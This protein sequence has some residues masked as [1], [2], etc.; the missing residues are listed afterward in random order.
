MVSRNRRRAEQLVHEGKAACAVEDFLAAERAFE[1]ALRLAPGE[2]NAYAGL[3]VVAWRQHR[4]IEASARYS[5]LVLAADPDNP[6][7]LL[8]RAVLEKWRGD[9]AAAT[10]FAQRVLRARPDNVRAL[11]ITYK[12]RPFGSDD[13]RFARIGQ[14]LGNP[15]LGN[16]EKSRL[17]FIKADIFEKENNFD[18]A[19]TQFT[20][21]NE[22]GA[23]LVNMQSKIFYEEFVHNLMLAIAPIAPV[24]PREEAARPIFVVGMPRSGSTLLEQILTTRTGV[25]SVGESSFLSQLWRASLRECYGETLDST[26]SPA[27]FRAYLTA[28]RLQAMRRAYLRQVAA[29]PAG[30][31]HPVIVDKELNNY[32]LLPLLHKLFPEAKIIHCR[33]HHLDV[34]FSCFSKNMMALS[35][36]FRQTTIAQMIRQYARVMASWRERGIDD[37]I[38]VTYEELVAQ[39]QQVIKQILGDCGVDFDES[40]LH[41][42]HSRNVV[43]TASGEQ[44]RREIDRSGVGRWRNYAAHLGPLVDAL[45]GWSWVEHQPHA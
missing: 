8:D 15:L 36:A 44:V 34:G 21:A 43:D 24:E 4:D 11:E 32:R 31:R 14:L 25:G 41:P 2:P 22:I 38:D 42:E 3:A 12:L 20:C 9:K 28:P 7:V 37:F 6:N 1:E 18:A 5:D 16:E 13:P 40:A 19:F 27:K 35:Y 30:A 17:H 26:M 33:R 29:T 45:G 39:P 10:A 23:P